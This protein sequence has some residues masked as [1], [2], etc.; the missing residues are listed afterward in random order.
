MYG[1]LNCKTK[2]MLL[3]NNMLQELEILKDNI[4]FGNEIIKFNEKAKN[5]LVLIRVYADG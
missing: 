3:N 2:I 1:F 4:L 5:L